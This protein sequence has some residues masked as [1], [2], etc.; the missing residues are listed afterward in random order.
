MRVPS[1]SA[2]STFERSGA[3][4]ATDRDRISAPTI[5]QCKLIAC[6][7]NVLRLPVAA[8]LGD[9]PS[10]NRYLVVQTAGEIRLCSGAQQ[11]S[12]ASKSADSGAVVDVVAVGLR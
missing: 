10:Q 1:R 3:A 11:G 9:Q 2:F 12:I 5:S 8:G 7:R 6:S 4:C